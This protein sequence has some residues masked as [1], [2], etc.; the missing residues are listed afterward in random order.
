MRRCA[1][2][3]DSKP[4]SDYHANVR[5]PDGLAFYCK[6]CVATRSERSRR[7][8]G[9]APRRECP[10]VLMQGMKWCP[11]CEA[12]KDIGEFPRNKNTKTGRAPYCKPCHNAR[13]RLSKIKVGGS[14]T[15][16][17]KR[18]Y[19]ITAADADAMMAAQGGLCASP[20][21][22]RIGPR[23]GFAPGIWRAESLDQGINRAYRRAVS[24][25]NEAR[26]L[27]DCRRG[28]SVPRGRRSWTFS[29]RKLRTCCPHAD[30]RP[31]RAPDWPRMP[32][33]SSRR[34]S[35]AGS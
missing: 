14:R 23:V 30:F 26:V 5:R 35:Q 22:R 17:L 24:W 34:A 32:R 12:V 25:P 8:R 18:R 29:G 31:A 13:G 21:H 16:H 2:C 3:G 10:E 4:S 28:I 6:P 7:R 27:R 15:Y 33:R 1:D 9:I 19:G 11:D 20:D